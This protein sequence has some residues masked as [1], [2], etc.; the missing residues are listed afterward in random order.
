MPVLS[1]LSVCSP[2]QIK[3][4]TWFHYFFSPHPL[5]N[6][7]RYLIVDLLCTKALKYAVKCHCL[8]WDLILFEPNQPVDFAAL[9]F[10]NVW[11]KLCKT[12]PF[13][14]VIHFTHQRWVNGSTRM[15]HCSKPNLSVSHTIHDIFCF[16]PVFIKNIPGP[17]KKK[18]K[19]KKEN[20]ILNRKKREKS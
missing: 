8:Q 10:C 15:C 3:M 20:N 14:V 11:Y 17:K 4:L 16:L 9:G 12:F 6:C 7:R 13:S 2:Q 18:R 1:I 19:Q 5:Q